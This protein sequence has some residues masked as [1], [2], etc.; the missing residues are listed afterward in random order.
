MI[1]IPDVTV[2]FQRGKIVN[3]VPQQSLSIADAVAGLQFLAKLV[4]AGLDPGKVNVV[5]MASILPP[6]TGVG[7]NPTPSSPNQYEKNGLRW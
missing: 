6:E 1:N 7:A 4:D 3:E 2:S 5:N